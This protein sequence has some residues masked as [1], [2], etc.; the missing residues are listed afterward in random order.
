MIVF[1]LLTI[2]FQ[3]GLYD[4]LLD[5]GPTNQREEGHHDLMRRFQ[6]ENFLE[7]DAVVVVLGNLCDYFVAEIQKSKFRVGKWEVV[8]EFKPFF[9]ALD[10]N[11]MKI[12]D[13]PSPM[14]LVDSLLSVRK[15]N[16]A[17]NSKVPKVVPNVAENNS[18]VSIE[19]EMNE[20][21]DVIPETT[22]CSNPKSADDLLDLSISL[23]NMSVAETPLGEAFNIIASMADESYLDQVE[24]VEMIA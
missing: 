17:E 19:L 20:N 16:V 13:I 11:T 12:G 4:D 3:F 21:E 9:A 24:A 5:Q 22:T 18:L 10:K 8:E 23:I 14:E 7:I 2:I 1:F 6:E 15:V